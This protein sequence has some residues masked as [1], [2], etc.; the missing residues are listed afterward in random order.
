MLDSMWVAHYFS[1]SFLKL[2]ENGYCSKLEKEFRFQV[3]YT[4][5]ISQSFPWR[6]EL[7]VILRLYS[8]QIQ[9][10]GIFRARG[11]LKTL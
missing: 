7:K 5:Y 11:I 4:P 2:A 9:N 6:I 8:E 1:N 3:I 10:S